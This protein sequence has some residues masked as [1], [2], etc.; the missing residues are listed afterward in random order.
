[1]GYY[2]KSNRLFYYYNILSFS[3]CK[4]M[5]WTYKTI[6]NSLKSS[7]YMQEEMQMVS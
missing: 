3:T 6:G 2:T 5:E 1:M 7:P 4:A